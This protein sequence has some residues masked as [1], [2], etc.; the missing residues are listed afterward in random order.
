[1][2]F[3]VTFFHLRPPQKHVSEHA[4]DSGNR[5]HD[6][7]DGVQPDAGLAAVACGVAFTPAV[8]TEFV[9]D[10]PQS[11]NTIAEARAKPKIVM[12]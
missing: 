8:G 7:H 9:H 1:V 5:Y 6:K 12:V 3:D 10:Q 2:F 11:E 4:A